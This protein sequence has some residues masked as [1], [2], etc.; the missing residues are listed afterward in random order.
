MNKNK[1][2]HE[3]RFSRENIFRKIKLNKQRQSC[4]E[5]KFPFIALFYIYIYP[6]NPSLPPPFFLPSHPSSPFPPSLQALLSSVMISAR[7]M[8]NTLKILL[9]F[10]I[11][12]Y[13]CSFPPSLPSYLSPSLPHLSFSPSVP[14][15]FSHSLGRKKER[16]KMEERRNRETVGQRVGKKRKEVAWR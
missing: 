4:E 10:V 8:G 5:K 15:P 13:I 1:G 7:L 2:S 11:I 6:Y 14:L 12:I 3:S 16:K 9:I